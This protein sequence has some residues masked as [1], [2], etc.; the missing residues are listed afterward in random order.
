MAAGRLTARP[1]HSALPRSHRRHRPQRPRAQQRHRD[2]PRR[3][4]RS[5]TT[6]D[7]ER[8]SGA[9]PRPAARHPGPAQGQHRHRRPHAARPPARSRWPSRI[10]P[11]DAF[12]VERLR[13]A[14]AVILGKTNLSEWANFRST[15]STSGW[16][17]R[18]GLTRNPYVLDRNC[19]GSSSGS[20]AAVAANLCA[21]GGR[22]RNRRLDR[23][24][25]RRPTASSG[26]SRR[27]VW[28]AAPASSRSRRAR[29]RPGR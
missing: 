5:P 10:A 26:S 22:H 2:Q 28:S 6:L 14:G 7:R 8:Q 17:G 12:L 9:R 21:V 4:R 15:R 3:A 27:S 16:S 13:E 19:C 29:T 18:G 23:L 25:V 1:A 24:P 20:G 11:R